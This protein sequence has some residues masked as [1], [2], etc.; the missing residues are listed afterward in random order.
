V[1]GES[2]AGRGSTR[3]GGPSWV[4][5]RALGP[6]KGALPCGSTRLV[7]GLHAKTQSRANTILRVPAGKFPNCVP[8]Q[9]V[10]KWP[11]PCRSSKCRHDHIL[12]CLP[13]YAGR[14]SSF[15]QQSARWRA[16]VRANPALARAETREFVIG[17]HGTTPRLNC[18]SSASASRVFPLGEG[19]VRQREA[20]RPQGAD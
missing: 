20:K 13:R 14:G 16:V 17:S 11:S 5:S 6:P 10:G 7:I 18:V 9:P 15:P 3:A 19:P 1:P 4:G 2:L 12:V 8:G